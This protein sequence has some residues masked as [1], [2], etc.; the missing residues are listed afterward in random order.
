MELSKNT[1]LITGGSGG[2]GLEFA[3]QLLRLGNT[4]IITGRNPAKLEQA[5]KQYPGLV[6]YKSDVTNPDAI[7]SLYSEVTK[8]FPTLNIL[9]NNAGV[10]KVTKFYNPSE[11]LS[12]VTQEITTNLNGP[13]WMTHQFIPH[14]KKQ[15]DA[16]IVNVTSLLGIV[17]LP[18]SPVYSATK[19]GL[20]SFTMS[21]REQLKH[22]KIK[23]FDL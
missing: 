1:V 12:S 21:L 11:D 15:N 10:M 9:I 7:R 20:H 6:T 5:K 23:V 14:L 13:I 8:D 19:A 4:V 17:P 16:A 22:T 18:M 2:I 3:K